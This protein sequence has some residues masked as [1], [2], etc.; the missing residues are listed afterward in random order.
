[1]ISCTA[2]KIFSIQ[3]G[4]GVTTPEDGFPVDEVDFVGWSSSAEI[5]KQINFR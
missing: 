5:T 3:V 4:R 2:S 1:M